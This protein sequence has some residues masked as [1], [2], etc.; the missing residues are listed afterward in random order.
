MILYVNACVRTESRTNE[1]AKTLLDLIGKPY[2]ERKLSEDMPLPLSE[3][4][5]AYRTRLIDNKDYHDSIFDDAKEFSLADTI[6]ISAPYWDLSFP[7]IL[8]AYIENIYVAGIVTRYSADGMPEGL[9]RADKLYYVTTAGGSYDPR[10]SYDYIADL[11]TQYFGIQQVS[12]VK[13]EFL[14]IA[15]VNPEAIIQQ[16]KNNLRL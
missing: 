3:D 2:T 5:L 11:C 14:D 8:K 16:A 7:T 10:F 6:V 4:R 9:C 15:G 12:L 1:L 13:A